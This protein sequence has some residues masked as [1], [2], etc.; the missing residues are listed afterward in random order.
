MS[1]FNRRQL[2][3]PRPDGTDRRFTSANQGNQLGRDQCPQG[4]LVIYGQLRKK[5]PVGLPVWRKG[6]DKGSHTSLYMT[7]SCECALTAT[8][9]VS[10][11]CT[12]TGCQIIA[13][14]A[15]SNL[16]LPTVAPVVPAPMAPEALLGPADDP[17][18]LLGP[19]DDLEALLG[20]AD[21]PEA[22]LG[23]ADDPEAL[24]GPVDDLEALLGPADD[25]EALLGPADVHASPFGCSNPY[26]YRC[27]GVLN[28]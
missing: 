25:P 23:P 28:Y 16:H 22:L 6:K 7:A 18:A 26:C 12:D 24:L 14:E 2:K 17:E 8:I 15:L 19:V 13:L 20:P 1:S 11:K 21:D 27:F 10:D 5:K 4:Y 9:L 3:R